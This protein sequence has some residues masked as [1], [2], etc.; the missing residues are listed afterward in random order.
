MNKH[1]QKMKTG[2]T[3]KK[4]NDENAF[5]RLASNKKNADVPV[6]RSILNGNA[7]NVKKLK[8]EPIKKK[9]FSRPV[10]IIKKKTT[11]E[12]VAKIRKQAQGI[13]ATTHLVT[14]LKEVALRALGHEDYNELL[15]ED[16]AKKMCK[17]EKSEVE[18]E[19][20]DYA[21]EILF[22]EQD[23]EK[24]EQYELKP[25]LLEEKHPEISYASLAK[26]S[27]WMIAAQGDL[28]LNH[29]T[30]H[31]GVGLMYAFLSRCQNVKRNDLPKLAFS[32]LWLSIKF[33]ERCS[34]MIDQMLE[35]LCTHFD[36][37]DQ[38]SVSEVL[39]GELSLL[40]TIKYGVNRPNAYILL[41]RYSR[42]LDYNNCN[43]QYIGRFLLEVSLH[44]YNSMMAGESKRAAAC[45]CLARAITNE[46][47]KANE[48]ENISADKGK[49][50][51]PLAFRSETDN[52][53]CELWPPVLQFFTRYQLNDLVPVMK[54]LHHKAMWLIVHGNR[55]NDSMIDL[56]ENDLLKNTSMDGEN[57]PDR[58]IVFTC[59]IDKFENSVF[60]EASNSYLI[61]GQSM[62]SGLVE[63]GILDEEVCRKSEASHYMSIECLA[64]T[65]SH[66]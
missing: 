48:M 5:S 61:Y 12:P 66:E 40:R 17:I 25:F 44:S 29:E 49:N 13:D 18:V 4:C 50:R 30:L 43:V 60:M 24:V 37:E 6:K 59:T 2:L 8:T 65:L 10:P 36:L 35:C 14:K 11:E 63:C 41:R 27:N 39:N 15:S 21:L 23:R 19:T 26:A 57:H 38:F 54:S 56:D 46:M 58:D 53:L 34:P 16:Y 22:H 3:S 7:L 33:E 45:L 47:H 28:E 55:I 62:W 9:V 52:K 1:K 42:I 51:G 64:S 20:I 31:L 32:C